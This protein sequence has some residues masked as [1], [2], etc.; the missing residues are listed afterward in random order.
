MDREEK[1]LRYARINVWLT[2]ALLVV[3]G[4]HDRDQDTERDAE[5]QRSRRDRKGYAQTFQV[6][7]PALAFNKTL[8][9]LLYQILPHGPSS[10]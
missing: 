2:G 7:L 4:P 5:R 10:D 6:T 8:C 1:A 9:E 3:Q